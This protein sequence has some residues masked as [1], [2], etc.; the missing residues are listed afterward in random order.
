MC[1]LAYANTQWRN[2]FWDGPLS[3]LAALGPPRR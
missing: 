2:A 3:L 1:T